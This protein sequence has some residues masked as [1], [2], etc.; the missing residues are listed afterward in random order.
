VFLLMVVV[1]A[2]VVFAVAAVAAGQGGTLAPADHELAGPPVDPRSADLTTLTAARFPVCL[3][4]YR[5]DA[6]DALIDRVGAELAARDAQIADL[7]ARLSGG[8]Q[9]RL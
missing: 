8:R 5:M 9:D 2:G 1:I 7:T 6:V 4:G 3:R